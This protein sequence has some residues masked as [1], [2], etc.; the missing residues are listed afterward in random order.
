MNISI[1]I[2]KT[3]VKAGAGLGV[4]SIVTNIIRHTTP[5]NAKL[6][7]KVCNVGAGL[8]ISSVVGNIVGKEIEERA[9]NVVDM[10]EGV[11]K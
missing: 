5:A 9:K 11:K 1:S 2:I 4:G 3:I 10:L 7:E 6:L 8:V